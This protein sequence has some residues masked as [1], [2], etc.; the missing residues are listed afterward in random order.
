MRCTREGRGAGRGTRNGDDGV[1][2]DLGVLIGDVV[3][4]WVVELV[5]GVGGMNWRLAVTTRTCAPHG[6][7][8][9]PQVESIQYSDLVGD[10]H[11]LVQLCYPRS[12]DC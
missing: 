7:P 12:V 6:W 3:E 10:R 2:R 11:G 9:A 5:V 4:G 1:L 8:Q